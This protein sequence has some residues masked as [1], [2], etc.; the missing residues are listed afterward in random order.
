VSVINEVSEKKD[1]SHYENQFLIQD[2]KC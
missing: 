2:Q 1:L